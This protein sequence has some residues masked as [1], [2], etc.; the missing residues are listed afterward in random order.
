MIKIMVVVIMIKMAMM[1]V[2]MIKMA[3]MLM[4]VMVGL[5]NRSHNANR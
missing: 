3:M 1:L 5:A 4:V 2:I